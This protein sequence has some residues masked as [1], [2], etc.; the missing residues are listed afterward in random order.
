M[1][2]VLFRIPTDIRYLCTELRCYG[3]LI[4]RILALW[5]STEVFWLFVQVSLRQF[6][7]VDHLKDFLWDASH[8]TPVS[9][10][11]SSE[12]TCYIIVII[13]SHWV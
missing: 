13:I 4:P 2:Q 9:P 5:V 7:V 11:I 12:R 8:S 3:S 6:F 1:K 10:N